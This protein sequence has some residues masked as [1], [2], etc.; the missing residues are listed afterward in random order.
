MAQFLKFKRANGPAQRLRLGLVWAVCGL[1]P[2]AEATPLALGPGQALSGAARFKK[3]QGLEAAGRHQAAETPHNQAV[4]AYRRAN[5]LDGQQQAL[6]RLAAMD[7][8]IAD[9]LL[10]SVPPPAPTAAAPAARP[11]AA[12]PLAAPAPGPV[13]VATP[14]AGK[15]VA[16][17]PVGTGSKVTLFTFS[18]TAYSR[19]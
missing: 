16:G 3:A 19:Q 5:D 11:A 1:L 15:M 12:R 9:Q 10:A 7:E 14:P 18:G 17:Q 4:A 6:T 13:G 8:K 2:R